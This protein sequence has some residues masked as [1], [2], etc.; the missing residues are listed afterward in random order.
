L[1]VT[2]RTVGRL[3]ALAGLLVA[4]PLAPAHADEPFPV[5]DTATIT[6]EGDG[7]GHGKG[8]SQYGAY[9][10][11]RKGV[12]AGR[13]LD[14]YYPGTKVGRAAGKVAVLISADDDR[15][16]VVE[17]RTGLTLRKLSS[18][19]TWRLTQAGATRWRVQATSSGDNVVAYRTRSWHQWRVL[20][21]DV[22]VA[23]G[24]A[25]VALRTPAGT[26]RYRG[27]LRST[28]EGG[29]RV[30]V[31]V[32]PMEAYLRGVVPAEVAASAWPQQAMRAQ[33]VAARTY[34]AYERQ[35]GVHT[36]YD[37]C[38]T[39]ACQAYGGASAEY[40][41]SDTAVA[42]TAGRVLTYQGK[43]AF[44]QFTASNGGWTVDGGL[45][46]LV[47]RK[48]PWEGTSPDYYGWTAKV[49]A[50]AIEKAYNIENLSSIAVET[51]DGHGRRG[52]RVETVRL[53]STTGWTGTVTGESF[54]RNFGLRSTMFEITSVG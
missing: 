17:A 36:A 30:T 42:R 33:A 27:A 53:G 41:T 38:D 34:A 3:A 51:R 29:R 50:R 35:H 25:P 6:V 12:Q 8:L 21:G 52:G 15:D 14:F 16:L 54:R 2:L 39:D 10:A 13:I 45:P 37:L 23:A 31:N 5:P 44:T 19:K 1:T 49:S 20:R 43:T 40:P 26:V 9:G 47:A 28:R 7:S 4:V 18:G 22:E 11:A 48:D 32:L 46:Y 24:G